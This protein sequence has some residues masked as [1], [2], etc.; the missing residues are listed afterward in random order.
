MKP[1][2]KSQLVDMLRLQARLNAAVNVHWLAANNPWTRAIWIEAAEG[3]D[4]IGWKWWKKQEPN[5]EQARIELIDIWH[6]A[7]SDALQTTG[8]DPEAAAAA[9]LVSIDDCGGDFNILGKKFRVQDQTTPVLFDMLAGMA[10]WGYVFYP[11]LTQLFENLGMSWDDVYRTYVAKNVL[12]LFRQANGYK[13]G[14]YKKTWDGQE[15]NIFLEAA[16][17]EFPHDTAD[18]LLDRPQAKYA[19]AILS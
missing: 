14:T 11:A 8:G 9:I 13:E 10:A 18:L 12:N 6:F 16:M 17:R 7:L 5:V 2:S 1:L 4:H 3:L 15:D 19:V